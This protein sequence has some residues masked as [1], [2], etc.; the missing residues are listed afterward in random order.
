MSR[1]EGES[2]RGR[3]STSMCDGEWS[4]VSYQVMT[5]THN[6][7]IH[8]HARTHARMHARTHAR[9]RA[10]THTCMEKYAMHEEKNICM[11]KYTKVGYHE[12]I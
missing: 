10:R 4:Y 5:C 12:K 6:K 9:T 11:E 3:G 8:M 7:H 1:G 2:E